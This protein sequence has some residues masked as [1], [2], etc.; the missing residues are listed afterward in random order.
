MVR[1]ASIDGPITDAVSEGNRAVA[2]AE[3]AADDVLVASLAGAAQALYFAGANEEAWYAALRAVQHPEAERRPTAHALARS[4]LALVALEQAQ[5][6]LARGHAEKAKAIIGRVR[7]SRSWIGA[8]ASAAL[9]SVFM[10]EGRLVEAEREFVHAEHF[11]RDEVATVHHVW[12]LLLLTRVR[13]RRGKLAG[14]RAALD[15]ALEEL[16]ALPGGGRLTSLA[17]GVARELELAS[18]VATSGHVLDGP[19]EAELAVLQLLASDLSAREI[20]K[21]L[22]LSPNTIR[23]HTRVIYRKLGVNSRAEAVARATSLGLLEPETA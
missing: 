6:G 15:S 10:D 5:R 20:G 14:A 16:A 2:L 13:C 21:S 22:F 9:A 11:F 8:N 1:A 17:A 18:S 23:T 7:S 4:T 3:D 19:S 12:A